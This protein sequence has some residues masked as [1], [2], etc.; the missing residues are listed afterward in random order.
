[1]TVRTL[2]TVSIVIMMLFGCSES[3]PSNGAAAGAAMTTGGTSSNQTGI[4]GSDTMT[5]G[6][7]TM[8]DNAGPTA[9]ADEE[10]GG[11]ADAGG[12]AAAGGTANAGGQNDADSEMGGRASTGGQGDAGGTVNA[13]GTTNA[14]GQGDTGGNDNTGQPPS[15]VAT[16]DTAC[17]ELTECLITQCSGFNQRA[18]EQLTQQCLDRC[19]PQQAANYA[20]RT[21]D[22]NISELRETRRNIAEACPENDDGND[23]GNNGDGFNMLYIGHSFGRTFAESLPS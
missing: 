11:M 17:A 4:G 6:A 15:D 21:C 9:G 20:A 16:C 18:E 10:M 1:M 7:P 22:E 14:G 3:N 12:I 23:D 13:G 19:T 2:T 8:P 5:A